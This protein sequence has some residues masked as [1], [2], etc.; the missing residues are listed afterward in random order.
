MHKNQEG[1]S[2]T[3]MHVAGGFSVSM[4]VNAIHYDS[5]VGELFVYLTVLKVLGIVSSQSTQ[6]SEIFF[7]ELCHRCS[8]KSPKFSMVSLSAANIESAL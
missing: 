2:A 4:C 8:P 5:I 3:Y 6:N 1:G 7:D